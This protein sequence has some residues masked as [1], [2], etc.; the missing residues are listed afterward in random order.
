MSEELR[1]V[2][3][4]V[5]AHHLANPLIEQPFARAGWYFLAFCE[6]LVMREIVQQRAG[7]AHELAALADNIIVHAKWP[8]RWLRL[9][10]SPGGE[11]PRGFHDGMYEAAWRLS[12]LSMR[13]LDFEAAFTYATSGLVTL[14]IDGSRIKSSGSMRMDGRFDAY[15]RLTQDF[16]VAAAEEVAKSFSERVAASVRVRGASFD[17]DLNPKTVQAGLEALGPTVNDRFSLP[18]DWALPRFTLR[19]FA[20][21]ARV[22]WVVAF[23]HF[24]ARVI[25]A[26]SGCEALGYSRALILMENGELVQR[27]RRYSGVGEDA[28]KAIVGDLTYGAR[29]QANPDPALQPIIPLSSLLSR[30]H[31]T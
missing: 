12:E 27:I 9:A 6:E 10:C 24:Q 17:Y 2:E 11:V 19:E 28:V 21:V 29:E 30:C 8:L 22:L 4:E 15:D 3:R 25:A 26:L 31:L 5:D 7:T 16:G 18:K 1:A 23:I 14:T 13:Y 20:Q